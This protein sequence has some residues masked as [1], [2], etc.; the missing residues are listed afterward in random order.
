V[1]QLKNLFSFLEPWMR[2][3]A[4]LAVNAAWWNLLLGW[5]FRIGAGTLALRKVISYQRSASRDKFFTSDD[6]NVILRFS[7]GGFF[8]P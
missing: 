3:I 2:D 7:L 8:R 6:D 4:I 5:F 1:E